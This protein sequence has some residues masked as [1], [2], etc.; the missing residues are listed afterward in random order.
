MA[1]RNNKRMTEVVAP[2][3]LPAGPVAVMG[4]LAKD[5]T[6]TLVV[7]GKPVAKAK[8]P[9]PIPLQP[10]EPLKVGDDTA[11]AVGDYNVPNPF[12]GAIKELLLEFDN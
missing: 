1:V 5:G 2:R 11:F 8:A 3:P 7:A 4:A 10:A 12:T 9:G 6:L